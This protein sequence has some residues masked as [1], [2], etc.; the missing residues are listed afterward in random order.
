MVSSTKFGVEVPRSVKHA[1]FLDQKS[2]NNLWEEAIDKELKQLY[3]FNVF[4]F[5]KPGESL[6]EYQINKELNI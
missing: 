1:L 2:N 6:A 4:R 5:S 3:D